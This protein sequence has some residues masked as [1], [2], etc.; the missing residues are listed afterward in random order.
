VHAGLVYSWYPADDLFFLG[1]HGARIENA[2]VQLTQE[3]VA[4]LFH[5][6]SGQFVMT[7]FDER[8]KNANEVVNDRARITFRDG[9]TY[10]GRMQGRAPQGRG[11][12]TSR[13]GARIEGEVLERGGWDAAYPDPRHY[14]RWIG[15]V[16]ISTVRHTTL[17]AA[18]AYEVMSKGE[19]AL[20][21]LP[22]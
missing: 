17:G 22:R 21:I 5:D 3:P 19:K 10:V 1:E 4:L 8:M 13:E 16:K 15:P 9:S 14:M 7:D 2:E 6:L 18:G 12:L 11:V 20:A